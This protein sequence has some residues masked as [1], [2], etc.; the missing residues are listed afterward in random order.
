MSKPSVVGAEDKLMEIECRVNINPKCKLSVRECL[1]KKI[2]PA[3]EI[4]EGICELLNYAFV[5]DSEII[6]FGEV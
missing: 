3:T 5:T 2:I 4:H 1:K 6:F